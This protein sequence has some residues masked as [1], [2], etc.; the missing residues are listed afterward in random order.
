MPANH[1]AK[2]ANWIS[3]YGAMTTREILSAFPEFFIRIHR[4]KI[5]WYGTWKTTPMF[6]GSEPVFLGFRNQ[7]LRKRNQAGIHSSIVDAWVGYP[8]NLVNLRLPPLIRKNPG[9]RRRVA[10]CLRIVLTV[11]RAE[12]GSAFT[13]FCVGSH[14][15]SGRWW[16]LN[17]I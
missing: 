10:L 3:A 1:E 6:V 15:T 16:R 9:G 14:K 12:G 8:R 17:F 4:E 5:E 7:I 13:Q 2:I 11:M